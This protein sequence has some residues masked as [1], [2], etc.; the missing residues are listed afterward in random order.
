M[1][2]LKIDTQEI[3][4]ALNITCPRCGIVIEVDQ[5]KRV[6]WNNVE[7]RFVTH[8]LC[9]SRPALNI[10]NTQ[11][12]YQW[13]NDMSVSGLPLVRRRLCRQS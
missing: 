12:R 13:S 4:D 7:C 9:Y 1:T 2:P 6:D 5:L 3:R 10:N 8:F 11:V